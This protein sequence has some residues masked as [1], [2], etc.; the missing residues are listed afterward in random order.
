MP[1]F[2][3]VQ[4]PSPSDPSL[5]VGD[6]L[7]HLQ[8]NL[9]N[10]TL[11]NGGF[12]TF[13][14]DTLIMSIILGVLFLFFFWFAAKSATSGVPRGLQNFVESIL[15]FVDKLVQETFGGNSPFIGPLALTIFIWVFLMNSIDF[16]PVD[17]IPTILA[18]LGIAHF[19]PVATSDPNLTFALSI[20]IFILM[21]F[22]NFKAKGVL[23]FGKEILTSPFGLMLA[24]INVIFRVLED[25]VKPL[26]LALRLFGN[27]FAGELIFVLIALLPW[28]IQ[29][30]VGD[31]WSIFHI[32]IVVLQ[33]FIFMMLTIVYL[34]MA[35]ES[36]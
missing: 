12:W 21:I 25:C 28:W 5:Y 22:Y 27:M 24:P 14:I 3:S 30:P 19:K 8:L 35:N 10:W 31:A 1:L 23:G 32:L 9:H 34:S 33:A 13:N 16:L 4:L 7:E 29:W 36:H 18:G 11:G 2:H 20:S 17:L 26:S 15:E 6:H